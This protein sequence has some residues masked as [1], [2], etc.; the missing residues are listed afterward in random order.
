M[1]HLPILRQGRGYRSVDVVKVPH[2]RGREPFVEMSQANAGLVRRDLLED[3][4]ARMRA[5]LG[6]FSAR[7]LVATTVRAGRIFREDALPLGDGVQT[8][9]WRP[10]KGCGA[11]L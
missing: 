1:L 5:A 6:A 2:F 9:E 10:M 4:Q 3:A 11:Q 8:P 7:E